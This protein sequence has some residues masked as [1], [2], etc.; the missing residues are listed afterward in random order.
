MGVRNVAVLSPY[1]QELHQ[2]AIKF[3]T[4][5][6]FNVVAEHTEDV[7][8]K[9]LQD[10][11]AAH[12]AAVAKKLLASVANIRGIPCNQWVADAAILIERNLTCRL[13]AGPMP[14]SG[15]HFVFLASTIGKQRSP[16]EK[17]RP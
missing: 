6:G 11:T 4:D 16:G 3:L 5:S 7:V 14:T 8:F 9:R 12:I 1:P 15:R 17:P 10:V 2:S 13:S